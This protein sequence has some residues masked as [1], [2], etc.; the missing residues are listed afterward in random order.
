MCVQDLKHKVKKLIL[1]RANGRNN[2]EATSQMQLNW[3]RVR[4]GIPT[5]STEHRASP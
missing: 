2:G 5:P 1:K 4:Y 3:R